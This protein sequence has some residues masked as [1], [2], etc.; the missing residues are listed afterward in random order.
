MQRFPHWDSVTCSVLDPARHEKRMQLNLS[1]Y[2]LDN[3]DNNT[4]SLE[5]QT[6]NSVMVKRI[7]SWILWKCRTTYDKNGISTNKRNW[8]D[9]L[10]SVL[11]QLH[12]VDIRFISGTTPEMNR[13]SGLSQ[14][15]MKKWK[16][17]LFLR[18]N[19]TLWKPIYVEFW[20]ISC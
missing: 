10:G 8:A 9:K 6:M 2:N 14:E 11:D 5:L 20:V 3:S 15:E 4:Y 17:A 13:Q 18:Q 16:L 19:D 12:L 7:Y 1:L